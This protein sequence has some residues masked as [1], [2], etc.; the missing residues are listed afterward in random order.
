MGAVHKLDLTSD[1]THLVVGSITTPKYRYVAKDRPDIKVLHPD[2]IES[3]RESWMEG[4]EVDVAALEKQHELKP[5]TGLEICITGFDNLQLRNYISSTVEERGATYH[6]DLTKQVTHLI[7]AAP[8]GSKYTHAKQWGISIVSLKWLED[9]L[10]RG[11]ALD[12]SLYDP[13]TPVEE[14]GRGAFRRQPRPRTSLG[15]HQRE[16]T[17]QEDVGKKKLRRT[18]SSRLESQSQDM[19][20]DISARSVS[21][22]NTEADQWKDEDDRPTTHVSETMSEPPTSE[23][24]HTGRGIS[25]LHSETSETPGGLFSGLYVLIHGFEKTRASLLQRFLGPNGAHVVSTIVE[26]EDASRN[27]FFKNRY[28]LVPHTPPNSSINLPEVPSGTVIATEW[29]VERCI[30]YKRLLDPTDDVLSR[31]LWDVEVDIFSNLLVSTTG[32]AGVDLR[33]VAEAVKIMGA[34]YQ[35]TVLPSSSVLIS[36]S[37]SIKKEKAFYANKHHIPVVSAEWLWTCLRTKNKAPFEN[38]RV[39][40]PAFDPKDFPGETSTSSLTSSNMMQRKMDDP[41]KT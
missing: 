35:E 13:V 28:L 15:K 6:G 34:T 23:R 32:F 37:A 8:Q 26:L 5:F 25:G 41:A 18:A 7:A 12:E 36:G 40:V 16:S 30:H 33:Q 1:V 21:L 10:Y 9:S 19:W 17:A 11:M 29:W 2:W 20:Q 14:Q 24:P 31:P 27:A 38:F 39:Q 3:V 22:D 4:G